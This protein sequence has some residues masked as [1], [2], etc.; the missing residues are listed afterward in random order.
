MYSCTGDHRLSELGPH[1][2]KD[3]TFRLFTRL[4]FRICLK[5]LISAKQPNLSHSFLF[6]WSTLDAIHQTPFP[7]YF[8]QKLLVVFKTTFIFVVLYYPNQQNNRP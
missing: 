2:E 6:H 8:S 7:Q 4:L 5:A 3:F 1:S